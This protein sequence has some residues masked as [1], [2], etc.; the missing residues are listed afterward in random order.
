MTAIYKPVELQIGIDVGSLN[1]SVAI[2]DNFGNIIKEFEITHTQKGFNNFF[3]IIEKEAK[4][5]NA[6]ISIAME[7]YNGWARPLDSQILK[8]G[9]KLYNVN[10]VKLARFKE[11]FPASAKTDAI[12]A[13]KIV[14]LFSLQ[15]HLPIAKKYSKR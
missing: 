3:K 10:N 1:H 15:K 2:S 14:E 4:K 12:D 11:I 7:G 6:T 13:R 9:Y 8:R 5:A